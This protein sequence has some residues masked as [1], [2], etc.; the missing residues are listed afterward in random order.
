MLIMLG[1]ESEYRALRFVRWGINWGR[2]GTSIEKPGKLLELRMVTKFN[3]IMS[4]YFSKVIRNWN[5]RIIWK[6]PRISRQRLTAIAD[7]KMKNITM[8]LK[9]TRIWELE[10]SR[11]VIEFE[12]RYACKFL[13]KVCRW[14]NEQ[15]SIRIIKV[16]GEW[17]RRNIRKI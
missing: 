3:C 13:W 12:T 1:S 9:K 15:K 7:I 11:Y 6:R 14:F 10:E 4:S 2:K 16:I 17:R 5:A 8:L